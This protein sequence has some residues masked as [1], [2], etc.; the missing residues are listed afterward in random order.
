[1]QIS[2]RTFT[3]AAL[4]APTLLLRGQP[5]AA[6]GGSSTGTSQG[7]LLA[8]AAA[9]DVSPRTLPAIVNGYTFERS[10]GV[11]HDPLY[12][13]CLVLDDGATRVAIVV[14]DIC[15]MPRDLID[16]AKAAA[17]E[18]T[19]IPVERMLVSATHTHSAA[20]AMSALGS[21]A[22]ADFVEYLPG[23]IAEA[24]RLA[25][26]NLAPARIGSTVVRDAEH[27]FSRRWIMRPDRLGADPF[28]GQGD[29]ARMCPRYEDPDAVGPAGP[30]DADLSLLSVQTLQ[31]RPLALLANYSMHYFHA[32]PISAGYYGRFARHIAKRLD[33]EN[34]QPAFVA[35]MSQG[36][37]GDQMY[38]DYSRPD[39]K[40]N[41]DEYSQAVAEVAFEAYKR[42]EHC[43]EASL[44]MAET[45]LPLRRRVPDEQRLAW[46]RETVAAMEGR[47]PKTRPEI[48]AREQILLHESPTV[49]LKLQALRIGDVGITAIPCEVYGITGLKIKAGSPLRPTLNITLANGAEGYIPPPEQ[50]HLGGYSTWEARTAGLEIDAEPKIVEAMLALMEQV[51]EVPRRNPREAQSKG[52]TTVRA[53]RP[54]AY[55]PMSEFHGPT[56]LDCSGNDRHGAYEDG[57]AFHLAGPSRGRTEGEGVLRAAHF[58]GGRMKW[59]ARDLGRTYSVS[60]WIYN[61]M[62]GDARAVAGYFFSRGVDGV[63]GGPG[64]HLGIGGLQAAPNRLIFFNGNEPGQLLEGDTHLELKTW[65]H[66]LLVRNGRAVTVHLDGNPKPEISG[67]ADAVEPGD[68]EH[69]FFGGRSDNVANFAGKIGEV[70]LYDRIIAPEEVPHCKKV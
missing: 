12:A 10:V 64:D 57:V 8:G 3:A 28:G 47:P 5:A 61:G 50:H 44:A 26:A 23:R 49:D 68:P 6:L 59:V 14:V 16:Q 66:V 9:V 42:I 24:V 63:L 7:V 36:S 2:R 67:E 32:T 51:S 56:A 25:E 33:A 45:V 22:D 46:A 1:M 21:R 35:M 48:F 62:P 39:P 19:G 58:A 15:V 70:V 20:S 31:G 13:R 17:R 30:V 29:R 34:L 53:S 54:V 27:T 55:W 4:A 40:W 69:L 52:G 37:S 11:I 65:Y 43:P 41:I 18:Q 60:M 38:M